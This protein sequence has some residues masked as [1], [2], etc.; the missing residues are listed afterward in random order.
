MRKKCI[1]VDLDGTLAHYDHWRGIEHIG[2]PI[3]PMVARVVGWVYEGHDVWIY[4]ARLDSGK[5]RR[6]G[7]ASEVRNIIR[8][9]CR[10]YI[11]CSLRS[12][13]RKLARF[14]EFWD[15]RAVAVE[16]NTGRILGGPGK[17][18]REN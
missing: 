14:D 3:E 7:A 9:W 8:C 11:G 18:F 13:G 5:L 4:T 1:A 16:T 15:D 10:S 17:P 12:T 6:P 2:Q